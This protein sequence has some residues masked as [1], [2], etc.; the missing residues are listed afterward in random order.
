MD[1]F[2]LKSNILLEKLRT[3]ADGKTLVT[4]F[5]QFNCTALDIISAVAFGMDTD[6]L[7]DPNN[8]LNRYVLIRIKH[9]LIEN[10]KL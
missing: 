5:D 8:K 4:L 6:T 2:N 7:N 3:L 1:V 9:T 10:I